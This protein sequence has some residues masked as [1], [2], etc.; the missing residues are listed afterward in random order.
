VAYSY[1][2]PRSNY[3]NAP[4]S[5]G[6]TQDA[7]QVPL[8]NQYLVDN[9]QF[10]YTRF[11]HH[12]GAPDDDSPFAQ[13]M[14]NQYARTQTGFGAALSVNPFLSYHNGY[15]QSLGN[16]NDWRGR[17]ESQ[18]PELRGDSS[19]QYARGVRYLRGW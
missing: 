15:L 5:W 12:L 10:A 17:Y 18:S 13:W 1:F 4:G 7:S 8:G 16:I 6:G 14:R 11:L 2:D 3:G 9:P 19:Q